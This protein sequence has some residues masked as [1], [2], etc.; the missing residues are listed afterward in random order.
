MSQTQTFVEKETSQNRC[1]SQTFVCLNSTSKREIIRHKITHPSVG[2]EL[3]TDFLMDSSRNCFVSR[4]KAE[5]LEKQLHFWYDPSAMPVCQQSCSR[6]SLALH[7]RSRSLVVIHRYCPGS[8][9]N[10]SQEGPW[11]VS[12]S[13]TSEISTATQGKLLTLWNPK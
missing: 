11:A 8:T 2:T 12:W 13:G 6:A 4:G 5:V 9:S 7:R 3:W 10:K 1:I